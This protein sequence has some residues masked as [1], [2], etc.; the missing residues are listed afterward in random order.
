MGGEERYSRTKQACFN[1]EKKSKHGKA[2]VDR[3]GLYPQTHTQCWCISIAKCVPIPTPCRNPQPSPSLFITRRVEHQGNKH[4]R[5]FP[6]QGERTHANN[7][8]PCSILVQTIKSCTPLAP[9]PLSPW[10]TGQ[11]I[12]SQRH[13]PPSP[14]RGST[15]CRSVRRTRPT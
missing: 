12:P 3:N 1:V 10:R 7:T 11:H 9:F 2:C 8:F 5:S 14:R 13:R 4:A 15:P 6:A